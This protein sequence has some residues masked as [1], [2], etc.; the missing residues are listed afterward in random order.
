MQQTFFKL[1]IHFCCIEFPSFRWWLLPWPDL[2]Y[3]DFYQIVYFQS[4]TFVVIQGKQYYF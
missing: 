4:E 2:V 3:S 1:G